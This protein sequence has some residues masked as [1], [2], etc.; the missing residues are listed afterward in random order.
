[1]VTYMTEGARFIAEDETIALDTTAFNA[2]E[3]LTRTFSE[4]ISRRFDREAKY[5][6]GTKLKVNIEVL[7]IN[8]RSINVGEI[9]TIKE[10]NRSR[11]YFDGDS[12]RQNEEYIFVEY[13]DERWGFELIENEGNFT[14]VPNKIINWRERIK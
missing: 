9:I 11:T 2:Y 6:P 5:P 10:Y 14:K 13:P 7:R 12:E 8:G 4:I 1:M 3:E